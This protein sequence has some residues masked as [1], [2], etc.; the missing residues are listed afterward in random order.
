QVIRHVR[1]FELELQKAKPTCFHHGEVVLELRL[2][3]DLL[4]FACRLSKVMVTT[5]LNPSSN[6]CGLAV[7][8][9]GISNLPPIARTDL[10]NRL[11]ALIEQFRAVWLS[12]NLPCGLQ[13]SLAMFNSLLTK[14]IPENDDSLYSVDRNTP[15]LQD[16]YSSTDIARKTSLSA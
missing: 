9:V 3:M 13:T 2:A 8:N 7:I 4:L 10:A 15:L 6:A 14:L 1:K 5:G 16:L 11:L 12:R